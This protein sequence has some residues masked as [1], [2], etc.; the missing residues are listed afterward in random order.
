MQGLQRIECCQQELSGDTICMTGNVIT[1]LF[2]ELGEPQNTQV[3]L[4]GMF[5]FRNC[6]ND[7][8]YHS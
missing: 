6:Q 3:G 5:Y 1:E 2:L 8:I 7:S 4:T